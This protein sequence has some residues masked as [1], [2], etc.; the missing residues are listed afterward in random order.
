M[1]ALAVA[2]VK[3]PGWNVRTAVL[4]G[5]SGR[6]LVW[7]HGIDEPS[8]NDPLLNSLAARYEVFAP[9]H[10]GFH[11]IDDLR[12]LRDVHDLALY[13]DDLLDALDLGRV[14]V[15][16]VSFGGMIAAELAAH[17]RSRVDRLILA[18]P[19]GLWRDDEPAADPFPA[20][21]S[22]GLNDLLWNDPHSPSAVRSIDAFAFAHESPD[23]SA[24]AASTMIV[25]M[26]QGLTTVGKFIWPIPDKGL[27]RR[28]HRIAAPTLVVWGTRDRLV[29]QS[30]AQDFEAGIAGARVELL[31]GAGH[32]APYERTDAFVDLVADHLDVQERTAAHSGT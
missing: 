32:M 23:P 17:V 2:E 4:R 14:A 30:Y 6:Q 3:V 19:M 26:A 21:T 1:S 10:P 7:L 16:G 28:L 25:G 31:D 8:R 18:A 9:I 11:D 29:P 27:R 22:G 12:G 13:H 24:D 15:A 20:Y 5:G